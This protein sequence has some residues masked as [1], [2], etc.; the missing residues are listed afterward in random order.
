M[1]VRLITYRNRGNNMVDKN[2]WSIPG[3]GAARS[4]ITEAMLFL[5]TGKGAADR[6]EIGE[7]IVAL[8][9]ALAKGEGPNLRADP[10]YQRDDHEREAW[11]KSAA[12]HI[13]DGALVATERTSERLPSRDQ[14]ALM[15]EIARRGLWHL[16]NASDEARRLAADMMIE[17]LKHPHPG[18]DPAPEA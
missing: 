3:W 17:G 2:R 10:L 8:V 13:V 9:R 12:R 7:D 14:V 6:A 18:D 4:Q 1:M 5:C 11:A 16:P 15:R